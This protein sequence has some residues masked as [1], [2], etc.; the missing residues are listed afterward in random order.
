MVKRIAKPEISFPHPGSRGS[1][2]V[3]AGYVK[4]SGKERDS[5]SYEVEINGDRFGL[6][7]REFFLLAAFT[8]A[9]ARSTIK[10]FC[11]L[12]NG[13]ARLEGRENDVITFSGKN[14]PGEVEELNKKIEGYTEFVNFVTVMRPARRSLLIVRAVNKHE[15][16]K[17]AFYVDGRPVLVRVRTRR[18]SLDK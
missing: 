3:L 1:R 10:G 12:A 15:T 9:P 16:K 2:E 18:A 7:I 13:F 14:I 6:T 8:V 17:P 11:N 4:K 5:I